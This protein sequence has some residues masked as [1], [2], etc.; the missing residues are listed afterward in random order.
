M[1]LAYFIY[2]P[3]ASYIII[4]KIQIKIVPWG[5][6]ITLNRRTY[7]ILTIFSI[8][9]MLII[10]FN[11]SHMGR[12]RFHKRQRW[13]SLCIRFS[14]VSSS[15]WLCI[16]SH[17]WRHSICASNETW[18]LRDNDRSIS[19]KIRRTNGWAV[20]HSSSARRNILVGRHFVRAWR[21]HQCHHGAWQHHVDHSFG[22]SCRHLHLIWRP[23]LSC[24]HRCRA[25]F[26]H[27]YRTC[28]VHT[29]CH[30]TPC[31]AQHNGDQGNLDWR[32][33]TYRI[34]TICRF[35]ACLNIRRHSMASIL[36]ACIIG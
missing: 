16:E 3:R 2:S 24:L 27:I 25:A 28:L 31:S 18:R 22:H 35:N 30:Q 10:L 29:I 4:K 20:V 23:L 11:F 5:F 21:H 19:T 34:C 13:S 15:C 1:K 36:S 17:I 12:R 26:L 7:C 6:E 32:S 9:T 8:K 14:V 33:T